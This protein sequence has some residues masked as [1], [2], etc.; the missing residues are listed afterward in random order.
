VPETL[1]KALSSIQSVQR[2]TMLRA[3]LF[4]IMRNTFY[5]D[6]KKRGHEKPGAEDCVSAFR[7]VQPDHDRHIHGKRMMTAIENLPGHYREILILVVMRG[8]SHEDAALCGLAVGKG[9]KPGEP[10]PQTGDG[11]DGAGCPAGPDR[12]VT[13]SRSGRDTAT[14][15]PLAG[16]IVLADMSGRRRPPRW[17]VWGAGTADSHRILRPAP[18]RHHPVVQTARSGCATCSPTGSYTGNTCFPG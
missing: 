14:P 9:E 17:A 11:R 10:R 1:M 7:T 13:R 18:A 3:W 2:G 15:T 6:V 4:S 16:L 12:P 5:S 8:E